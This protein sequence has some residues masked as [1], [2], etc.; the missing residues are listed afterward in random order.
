MQDAFA[1][2]R[3]VELIS[4]RTCLAEGH[5]SGLAVHAFI[6]RLRREDRGFSG[7]VLREAQRS[8]FRRI[9]DRRD[10]VDVANVDGD[11]QWR[12]RIALR[13]RCC[14]GK[15]IEIPGLK[16]GFLCQINHCLVGVS[17]GRGLAQFE[18]A[19]VVG[20]PKGDF[21]AIGGSSRIHNPVV[22]SVYGYCGDVLW[23][24]CIVL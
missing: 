5:R 12:R 1:V 15:C 6:G 23:N 11:I 13:V 14:N 3:D 17:V 16:V 10:F 4:I 19:T 20:K 8:D 2:V 7:N 9:K 24:G 21:A 18:Q 22:I